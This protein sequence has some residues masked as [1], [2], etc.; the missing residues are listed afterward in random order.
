VSCSK[1]SKVVVTQEHAP[2]YNVLLRVVHVFSHQAASFPGLEYSPQSFFF[3]RTF[4]RNV[5][6]EGL[7]K[8]TIA[9]A[10]FSAMRAAECVCT[11]AVSAVPIGF[12]P[13]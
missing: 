6:Y 8:E 9:S 13:T 7:E 10:K 3:G 11:E 12:E 1:G 5:R 4:W 2:V